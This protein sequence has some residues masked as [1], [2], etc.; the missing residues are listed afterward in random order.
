GAVEPERPLAERLEVADSTD[1]PADQALD[2]DRPPLLAAGPRLAG[3]ALPSGRRQQRVLRGHPAG[4]AT[5]HP[6]RN[7]VVDRRRAQHDRLP[8]RP[9]H[10]A[11]RLLEEVRL[12][13]ERPQLVGPAPVRPAHAA[14]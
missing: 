1:S 8:L 14:A 6:A 10:A 4:A 13:L 9:E 11:V 2:L 3:G 5:G 12:Q 7:T